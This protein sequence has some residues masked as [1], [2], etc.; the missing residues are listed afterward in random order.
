MAALEHP[1]KLYFTKVDA[2]GDGAEDLLLGT[3]DQLE[4]IWTVM[5]D[6]NDGT[7]HLTFIVPPEDLMDALNRSWPNME[8]Y[9]ITE[10]PLD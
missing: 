9:P 3:K 7:R 1:E 6:E 2:N 10:Y 5:D 8:I 4:V